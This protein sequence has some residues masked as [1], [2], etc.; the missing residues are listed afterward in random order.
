MIERFTGDT[1]NEVWQQIAASFR[2]GDGWRQQ[3]G[4]GGRTSELLHV[5][6]SIARPTERWVVSR[7]PALNPGF[8]LAEVVWIVAGREDSRFVNAFYPDLTKW[9]GTGQTYHGAYGHRLRRRFG[10]DQLE[11][12]YLA[13]K[14]NPDSRQVVLQLWDARADLPDK[15]GEARSAD[16]PCNVM[17]LLKIRDGFLEWM[18]IIRSNDVWRGLPHNIVQ[19]TSLQ[20]IMAG[21]LGCKVGTYNLISDSLHVYLDKEDANN[22]RAFTSLDAA[23]NEDSIALPKPESDAAFRELAARVDGIVCGNL[24]S[25][26]IAERARFPSAPESIQNIL[27]V[28]VAELGRRRALLD[29]SQGIMAECTN[30]ALRQVWS[31]WLERWNVTGQVC[32]RPRPSAE[33][34]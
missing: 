9:Q 5:A 20:E 25:R 34:S 18:Q 19:F 29:L 32:E 10:I 33:L 28:L 17:S 8:A 13:L 6:L 12:A 1:A 30:P 23:P 3:A 2:Q 11:R 4:R 16:V 27:R 7:S 24:T 14:E 22:V 31:C 21:W 15:H 26:Q